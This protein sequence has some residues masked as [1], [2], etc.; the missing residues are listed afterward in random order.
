MGASI[1]LGKIF[2]IPIQVNYSWVFIFLLFTYV[3]ADSDSVHTPRVTGQ[4]M[5]SA[6]RPGSSQARS[7]QSFDTS[8][9]AM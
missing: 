2:G 4:W 8:G 5:K 6:K 3:L 7:H 1:P 9:Y